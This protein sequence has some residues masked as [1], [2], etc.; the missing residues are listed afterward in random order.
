MSATRLF[1]G[2]WLLTALS[3]G[4]M[5]AVYKLTGD[6]RVAGLLMVAMNGCALWWMLSK[7]GNK[8]TGT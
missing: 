8:G 7:A 2:T 3:I 5:W 4:V 1:L 6:H